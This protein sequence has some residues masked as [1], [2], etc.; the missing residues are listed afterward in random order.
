[1]ET[2]LTFGKGWCKFW[3]FIASLLQDK[4][5]GTSTKRFVILGSFF[6]L[7][8]ICIE[9]LKPEIVIDTNVLATVAIIVLGG[10]GL[11]IPEWFSKLPGQKTNNGN[12]PT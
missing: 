6:L 5:E 4:S 10:I 7:A 9:S 11:T 2:K 3:S 12:K 1:M 8:K